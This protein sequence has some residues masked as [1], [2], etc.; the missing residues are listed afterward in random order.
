MNDSS[1][2]ALVGLLIPDTCWV[3]FFQTLHVFSEKNPALLKQ[4]NMAIITGKLLH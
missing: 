2:F 4:I 1:V 3:A